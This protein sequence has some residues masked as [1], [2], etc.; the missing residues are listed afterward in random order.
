MAR[1]GAGD[2]PL[3]GLTDREREVLQEMATGPQ[4]RHHRH[5]AVHERAGRGE[6]HRCGVPEARAGR[7]ARDQPAR[8]GGPGLSGSQQPHRSKPDE[9]RGPAPAWDRSGRA[10]SSVSWASCWASTSWSCWAAGCSSAAPTHPARPCR[11]W[12]P[13]VVALAFAPVQGWLERAASR[14]VATPYDVLTRFAEHVE[15]RGRYRGSP[16]PHVATA[17]AGHGRA[18]GPGLAPGVRPTDAGRTVAAG[19]QR[20]QRTTC[21]RT[22]CANAVAA[23][24]LRTSPVRYGD[25]VLGV[26]R[27]QERPGLPLTSSRSGCSPVWPP[28][29]GWC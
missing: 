10:S 6:A 16:W 18:V 28:R 15:Q 11:C 4:Q 26:L 25:Q 22:A 2:G 17:R 9:T 8:D 29:P 27:L 21:A 19:R 13:S 24:G 5:D 14:R 1:K 7:R 23:D 20:R 12:R 3:L